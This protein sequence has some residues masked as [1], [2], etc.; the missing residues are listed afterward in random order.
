[1]SC[2]RASS[3]V[4]LVPVVQVLTMAARTTAP[5]PS[6]TGSAASSLKR[7][8]L[9]QAPS[10]PGVGG[11]PL[12]SA[13]HRLH[14]KSVGW[15]TKTSQVSSLLTAPPEKLISTSRSTWREVAFLQPEGRNTCSPSTMSRITSC[16]E[17]VSFFRG[18]E[19]ERVGGNG[20]C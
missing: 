5:S 17:V 11:S 4:L 12:S 2:P 14:R 8:M 20:G 19:G 3:H 1:M 18:E 7:G 13:N 15:D 16:D 9:C 6:D 10:A